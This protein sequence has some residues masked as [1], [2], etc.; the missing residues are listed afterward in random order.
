MANAVEAMKRGALRLPDQ[1]LRPRRRVKLL[2]QRV[3]ETRQLERGQPCPGEAAQT[4]RGRVDIIG[5]SPAMT[6]TSCWAASRRTTRPVP[7]RRRAA[8]AKE[9]IAKAIHYHS[10]RWQGHS[11]RSTLRDPARAA[12]ERALRLRARRLHW[13]DRATRRQVRRSRRRHAVLD[14]VADMRRSS[15]RRVAARPAGARVHARRRA[16]EPAHRRPHRRRDEIRSWRK[17][18][19]PESSARTSTSASTWCCPVHVPLR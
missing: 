13:R 16:R 2:V 6:I 12:R 18:G 14:E 4:L 1:T 19:A 17:R 5:Q 3:C 8:P 9:L 7:D 10:P 11:S 15:R